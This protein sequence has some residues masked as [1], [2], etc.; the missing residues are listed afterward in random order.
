[1]NVL[2]YLMLRAQKLAGKYVSEKDWEMVKVFE[3]EHPELI[4]Q[5]SADEIDRKAGK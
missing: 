2:K 5:P 1:M 4:M 3:R